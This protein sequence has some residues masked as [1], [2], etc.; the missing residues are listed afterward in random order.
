MSDTYAGHTAQE[1]AQKF[2][3][4][5]ADHRE[6][7]AAVYARQER[8][9]TAWRDEWRTVHGDHS[10]V[11][12]TYAEAAYSANHFPWPIVQHRR[13]TDW[14]TINPAAPENL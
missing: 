4:L 13:V 11:Y 12:D 7:T 3:D 2:H 10:H 9:R 8:E 6:A 1:W 14:Q 5:A